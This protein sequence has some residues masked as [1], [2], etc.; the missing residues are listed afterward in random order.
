[1]IS[2]RYSRHLQRRTPRAISCASLPKFLVGALLL[3]VVAGCR[4]AAPE[5]PKVSIGSAIAG[6]RVG[7]GRLAGAPWVE[8][9]PK[10]SRRPGGRLAR[11]AARELER[12][13]EPAVT[14]SGLR[15]RAC[16]AL[17]KGEAGAAVEL[18]SRA[19]E[20]EPGNA[21]LWNDR[22]VAHLERGRSATDPY[23]LFLALAD[24]NRAVRNDPHLRSARFNRALALEKL[25]LGSQ[26]GD[27]WAVVAH[28]D[29]DP[30]WPREAK[31]GAV[32]L[33]QDGAAPDWKDDVSAVEAAVRDGERGR[34]REIVA[35]SPGAFRTL[36]E[37]KLLPGWAVA[38]R[39]KQAKPAAKSLKQARS[40]ATA[41]VEAGGD[42]MCADT[43]AQIDRLR[44]NDP[45][46]RRLVSGLSDYSEG[47]DRF[48]TGSPSA[49]GRFRSAEKE[50][51]RAGS[52]FAGWASCQ[53]AVCDYQEVRYQEARN[54]LKALLGS[55]GD[56]PYP[57]LRGYALYLLG[58]IEGI[59]GEHGAAVEALKSAEL[60]FGK[61]REQPSVDKARANLS[62]E[63]A[64]LGRIDEA[65][66]EI[67]PALIDRSSQPEETIHGKLYQNASTLAEEAGEIEIAFWFRDEAVRRF[68]LAEEPLGIV[69]ALCKRASL[70]AALGQGAEAHRDLR[71][72][73]EL[74]G[75]I[76]HPVSHRILE[77]D[78]LLAEG[79]MAAT[80]SPR[81]AIAKLTAAIAIFGETKYRYRIGQA[82]YLRARAAK[83]L[84]RSAAARRDL[85]TA[86]DELERQRETVSSPGERVSYLDRRKE[87]F[88]AMVS[89]QLERGRNDLALRYSEQAKARVLADW[90]LTAPSLRSAEAKAPFKPELA[91]PRFLRALP[92][93]TA[94]VEF[95]VMPRQT[96]IW[97]LHRRGRLRVAT[98]D[99]GADALLDRVQR[100]RAAAL[101]QR[102]VD[103]ES[104]SEDLHDLLLGKLAAFIGPQERL[105]LIPDGPLHLLPFA[106]LRNRRSG[107]YLIQDHILSFSP[108]ARLFAASRQRD[109]ELAR[110]FDARALVLAA[111]DFDRVLHPSLFPLH[112]GDTEAR[113]GNFFPGSQVLAGSAATRPAFLQKAGDFGIVHFGGHSV[114][115]PAFP[116]RSKMLLATSPGDPHRGALESGD[117]LGT[118][119][120]HTRLVVLASCSTAAGQV[121]RTEGVES[122][123]RPFLAAG[124]PSVVA[125]LLN[126]DDPATADFFL[127]FYG[128]LARN[129]DVPRALQ[130][131]QV[132][133]LRQGRG[134]VSR[135]WIWGAF[136]AIG[137]GAPEAGSA[138]APE[139]AASPRRRPA[140]ARLQGALRSPPPAR[141]E[142]PS[143]RSAASR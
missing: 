69:G 114:I 37:K 100:L 72:A 108:S 85:A 107:R 123:A 5:R 58:V 61:V 14:A 19:I 109:R 8:W 129:F 71:E 83:A 53:I 7:E 59:G 101:G 111:P 47:L 93:R 99:V 51:K 102:I 45:R 23:P 30:A 137:G 66:R 122:L 78:L 77:G 80:R 132:E 64:T 56:R 17:L 4:R 134:K 29:G 38:E 127:R 90:V 49:R 125:S 98:V 39:R 32:R 46:R 139:P 24:A 103:L 116:L 142:P 91:L 11:Q 130:A 21:T 27:D 42:R 35:R 28:G 87:I 118:R 94:V 126:V 86:I 74:L 131:A 82:L 2:K 20:L 89:L 75:R 120:P 10:G 95:A 68:K 97:V 16:G 138:R 3:A 1:M 73:R 112:A 54:G 52:P 33:E 143:S 140:A 104:V 48:A 40:I 84:G 76:D 9:D 121:S 13:F 25:G 81:K 141:R 55:L 60:S 96:V 124:V 110:D 50:L 57:F 12:T 128:N 31:N 63:L 18:F 133:S 135:P 117:L 79:E 67:H 36:C 88:D 15:A 70:R 105:V 44:R 113:I 115:D 136:E 62:T 22:A 26:A 34:V 92:D 119:F 41:L 106:L 65:W 6:F 43:I